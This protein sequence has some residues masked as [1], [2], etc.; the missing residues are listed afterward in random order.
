MSVIL[1]VKDGDRVLVGTDCQVSYGGDKAVLVSE[2][3][4]KIWEVTN[5]PNT[6]MGGVGALRD[7][8][9]AYCMDSLYES[10][11]DEA[12][13]KLD[14]KTVVNEI[15]PTMLNHFG[16]HGRTINNNGVI[17]FSNS[18]FILAQGSECFMI[19]SDGCVMDLSYD[20]ECMSVGSGATV[21]KSA[22]EALAD[23]DGLTVE[24]KMIKA[25]AQTCEQDR[26]VNYPVYIKDTEDPTRI[27]VFDGEECVCL[28][29]WEDDEE[30][31]EDGE[32]KE[33]E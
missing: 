3:L 26:G 15:V 19:D 18:S 8:N 23:L 27:I 32:E 30:V 6:I 2:N 10:I 20:L 1:A 21:A 31:V 25:L 11:R 22:F 17:T 13:K 29:E 28:G 14:F 33:E 5:H 9:I 4:R 12:G 7:L 24:E 16:S